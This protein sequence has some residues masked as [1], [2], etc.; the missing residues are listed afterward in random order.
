MCGIFGIVNYEGLNVERPLRLLSH[1]GPDDS[2][3]WTDKGVVLGHCR[4]S[5]IDIEGG[6]QPW[7]EG[8]RALVY[9]GEVYNFLDL[10]KELIERGIRFKSRSDTEVI[11]KVLDIYGVEGIKRFN[12]MFAFGFWDGKRLVLARDRF[13]IKPLYWTKKDNILAFSSE[14]KPLLTLPFVEKSPNLEALKYHITFLWCPHPLT[15][16]KG[17]YK[18]P[19][20]N[21]LI[22]EDGEVK[23]FPFY[24]A[25]LG[26]DRVEP[27]DIKYALEKSVKMHLIAD[28]EVGLFLSGGLDSS[29]I[30]SFTERPL[31]AFSLVFEGED[32]KRD[33]FSD[34]YRFAGIVAKRFGHSLH[35]IKVR[36]NEE[37]FERVVYHLEEP[38]GDGAAISNYLLS[39]GAREM[40]LKVALAGTGGDELWGGYPRYR[41]L[42]I[43]KNF[44]FLKY[45]PELPFSSGKLG[46]L[47]RDINKFKTA[48]SRPFPLNYLIWMSYYQGFGD[49][50]KRLID[51]FPK[52]DMLNSCMLFDIEH[53]L[54]DHNLL[55]TDKTSMAVGLEIRVPMLSNE[56]LELALKTPS[57]L[58]VDMFSGKKILKRA[59]K[60]V[61][62]REVIYRKK[63]GFGAPVKGWISGV[64]RDRVRDIKSD[65]LIGEILPKHFVEY[66]IF[67]NLKGRGFTYL[68]LFELLTIS[69]WRKLFG[70]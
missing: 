62:P 32:I 36:F 65:P 14:I 22:Y 58:K 6:K 18:L 39:K 42:I 64:L 49:V 20:G 69:T 10:Q 70:L 7:V 47:A 24:K 16:F 3:I 23:V 59:L 19:P 53:F 21:V 66:V 60:G 43:A 48:A 13:G 30:A 37:D 11:F 68:T 4:L 2:G 44:P 35:P 61:L 27:D 1:R 26:E 51:G 57:N 34:E 8:G 54:P 52:G 9:N 28:V 5:I 17:I 38:V 33:I 40:G 63:A 50:F 67:E 46:R 25:E 55:Y 41:A 12:G 29:A 31:R 45:I 15:A 56:L